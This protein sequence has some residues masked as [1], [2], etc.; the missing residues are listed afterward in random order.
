MV[1]FGA[2][3][4]GVSAQ[5]YLVFLGVAA[6]AVGLIGSLGVQLPEWAQWAMFALL[7]L[8]SM[9]SFR[10]RVYER[11]RAAP[12]EGA[13]EERL[14][15]GDRVPV[16]DTL[17]PGA[18]C[19]VD[20]RGTSWSARNVGTDSLDAGSEAEIVAIDGLTLHLRKPS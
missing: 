8:V 13:V 2:E 20:F 11:L 15:H 18:H 14:S 6:I 17:A 12:E 9:F 16:P 5:F 19:R 4:F 3:L 7:A 10:R 1:L